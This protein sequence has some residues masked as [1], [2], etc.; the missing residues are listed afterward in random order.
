MFGSRACDTPMEPNPKLG[1]DNNGE[2]VDKGDTKD[3][4]VSLFIYLTLALILPLQALWLVNLCILY[5]NRIKWLCNEYF[6]ILSLLLEK[7]CSLPNTTILGWKHTLMQIGP[8]QSS[9]EGPLQ[10][11][12][13]LWEE[14]LL[15]GEVRNKV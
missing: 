14:I 8:T 4:L 11:I 2:M 13:H 12:A 5:V 15:L 1:D 10:D 7:F 3:L 9:I 6:G